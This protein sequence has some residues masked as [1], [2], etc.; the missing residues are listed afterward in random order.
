MLALTPV[1][2]IS[3][4]E[5]LNIGAGR[6]TLAIGLALLIPALLLLMLLS[7]RPEEPPEIKEERVT[8][9]TI[10]AA[11]PAEETPEPSSAEAPPT[12]EQPEPQ[13]PTSE[14]PLPP[15]P[16]APAAATPIPTPAERPPSPATPKIGVRPPGGAVYGPPDRGGSS[17]SRD[18]ARVGT[19]PNGEPLDAAAWYREP[20]DGELRG[21]LSTASGPG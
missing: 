10:A 7:F 12:D 4:V 20:S 18:T 13:P 2:A 1:P 6:R 17:A 19:A 21:Y 3:H 16:V 5:Q 9:V 14:T 11:E 8:M 15:Q